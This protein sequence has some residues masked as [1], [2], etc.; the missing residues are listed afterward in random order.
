MGDQLSAQG[1]T[2]VK[3]QQKT[4]IGQLPAYLQ[5]ICKSGNV[6]Q[7][8]VYWNGITFIIKKS[9]LLSS[10]FTLPA[11]PDRNIGLICLVHSCRPGHPR[12]THLTLMSRLGMTRL[13]WDPTDPR[14]DHPWHSTEMLLD[15]ISIGL[16]LFS[17]DQAFSNNAQMPKPSTSSP[18]MSIQI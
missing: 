8:A 1:L 12:A 9:F 10:K 13:S 15:I 11:N 6:F 16:G 4:C 17:K 5:C 18:T 7:I 2:R 3:F 14:W